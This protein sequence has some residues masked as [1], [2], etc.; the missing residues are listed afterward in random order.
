[1]LF[2]SPPWDSALYWA[3]DLETSGLETER[4]EILSIGMVPIRGGV[5]HYGSTTPANCTANWASA[6]GNVTATTHAGGGW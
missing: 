5:I 1:M 6:A 3:L 2:G 4:D